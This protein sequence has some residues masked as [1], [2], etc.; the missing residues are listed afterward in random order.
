MDPLVTRL[1]E[2]VRRAEFLV[3]RLEALTPPPPR[4]AADHKLPIIVGFASAFL[5]III[6]FALFFGRQ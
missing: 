1:E 6:V 2:A 5:A 4:S 3:A